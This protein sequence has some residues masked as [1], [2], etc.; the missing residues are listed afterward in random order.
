MKVVRRYGIRAPPFQ[1]CDHVGGP[2][3]RRAAAGAPGRVPGERRRAAAGTGR[4]GGPPDGGGQRR[5]GAGSAATGDAQDPW[6][7]GLVR[8]LGGVPFSRRDGGDAPTL[9]GPR[10]T[11][12]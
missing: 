1:S 2:H 4:A 9:G 10:P 6:V 3:A 11:T 8:V 12:P 7:G 5:R